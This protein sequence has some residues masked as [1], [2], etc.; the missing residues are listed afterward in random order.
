MTKPTFFL[1]ICSLWQNPLNIVGTVRVARKIPTLDRQR[2]K[3]K[4][5]KNREIIQSEPFY[6]VINLRL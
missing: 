1:K 6:C 2:K 4:A 5:N 3:E